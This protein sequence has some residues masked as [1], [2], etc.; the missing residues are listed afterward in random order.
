M[1]KFKAVIFF[2]F[3]LSDL[4]TILTIMNYITPLAGTTLYEKISEILEKKDL[5][6]SERIPKLRTVQENLFKELTTDESRYFQNLHAREVYIFK[7]YTV[8][9]DLS[10]QIKSLRWY[11][12]KVVH[13]NVK[14][15]AIDE[16]T[17]IKTLCEAISYFSRS[18]IPQELVTK[19]EKIAGI[20]K[21]VKK[22]FAERLSTFLLIE[23]ISYDERRGTYDL[24]CENEELGQITLRI[25]PDTNHNSRFD[26]SLFGSQ[27]KEFNR[28]YITNI[29]KG[30]LSENHYDTTPGTSIVLEPDYLIDAKELSEC[31][32]ISGN[33]SLIHFLSRFNSIK[34]SENMI[35]GNIIGSIL[36]DV[37]TGKNKYSFRESF[38]AA[39]K[40]NAL[41]ILV[42]GRIGDNF[43]E[44]FEKRM[45]INAQS[46]ENTI[47]G[48]ISKYNDSRLHLEPTFISE[49]Y[50]LLGR[51]D[52]LSESKT[53]SNKKDIIEL[54]SGTCPNIRWGGLFPNHEAQTLCYDLLLERPFPKRVGTNYVF[55]S[56][57]RQDEFPLRN[58]AKGD[59]I[60]EIQ[61]L[62]YVRNQIVANDFALAERDFK[63]FDKINSGHFGVIPKFLEPFLD[64]FDSILNSLNE[65]EKSYFF[66]Y[67]GFIARELRSSKIGSNEIENSTHGFSALWN[68]TVDEK[69]E[70][71]SIL[72]E[73]E[74][75]DVTDNFHVY[76]RPKTDRSLF[77]EDIISDLRSK[78]IALLIPQL[79]RSFS[80]TQHQILKCTIVAIQPSLIEIS[81]NNKQIDKLY[82][83]EY[84]TWMLEHD[85]R[86]NSKQL[87]RSVFKFISDRNQ[88]KK[89]LLLG[90]VE[91]EFEDLQSLN[92]RVMNDFQQTVIRKALSAK[93]Y[94]LIQGP[95]GTG[96]T[97]IILKELTRQLIIAKKSVVILAF[98]NR[99]V[100][101]IGNKLAESD[102]DYLKLGKDTEDIHSWQEYLKEGDI[103]TLNEVITNTSVVLSTQ[104]S[105]INHAEI[106]K[107]KSFD[108][109]IVD[110]ASQLLEPQLVGT[111]MDFEKFI[112]I[113]DD[114]QLPPITTQENEGCICKNPLMNKIGILNFND[115]L[116]T[117]LYNNAKTRGWDQAIVSLVHHY[118]MHHEVAQFI[119]INHYNRELKE[120]LPVQTAPINLFEFTSDDIIEKVL[121]TSRVIFIPTPAERSHNKVNDSEAFLA[122]KFAKTIK[123]VYGDRFDPGKTLGIITPYRAQIANIKSK[124]NDNELSKITID[125]VERFQGSEREIIIISLS[126]KNVNQLSFMQSLNESGVD[127]KLNVALSRAKSHIII[128]GCKEILSQN[129]TFKNLIDFIHQKNGIYNLQ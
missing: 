30:Q 65:I 8:P 84:S 122:L 98:T 77:K 56:N 101:E 37:V 93:D 24:V 105:F 19:Y 78:D 45:Q 126:V 114:K 13:E 48:V 123:Q 80:P 57:A 53:D 91:P 58:T 121:S 60:T 28:I 20:F 76:L 7:T 6:S 67:C 103:N 112:L 99:A 15:T 23:Q 85:F 2:N 42:N 100:D 108:V 111:I 86:D 40:A 10:Q 1:A 27:L 92:I 115:S 97:S 29:I 5:S 117:R 73:L 32:Q 46:Q 96:K 113:G 124:I 125:T 61:R 128:L 62:I 17:C 90:K 31:F 127:R 55:Y 66:E 129:P 22:Q 14:P 16:A 21:A 47:K 54:K 59:K 79:D 87:F 51:L 107:I 119:N 116:F 39:K 83:K 110:E 63:M 25:Y 109:L 104:L 74:I 9:Y 50:G 106:L 72:E 68:E 81:L 12:N 49:K 94:F 3:E 35:L 11:S 120:A 95:P 64:E 82:F 44:R 33:N 118:R 36:D 41:S 71:F 18:E 34:S 26:L 88:R 89:D 38:N 4:E 43:D 69:K 102:I 52:I 70:R 75:V